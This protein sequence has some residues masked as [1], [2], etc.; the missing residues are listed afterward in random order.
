MTQQSIDHALLKKSVD[1]LTAKVDQLEE[2]LSGLVKAWEA[3]GALVGFVKWAAAVATAITGVA[4][5]IK[6]GVHK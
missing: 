5:F 6:F 1:D 4:A 3:A 2:S